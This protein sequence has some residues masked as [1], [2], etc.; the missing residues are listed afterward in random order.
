ME[1]APGFEPGITVLQTVALA[2]W[3]CR[4]PIAS[5][6]VYA[7]RARTSSPLATPRGSMRSRSSGAFAEYIVVRADRLALRRGYLR[8]GAFRRFAGTPL[9]LRVAGFVVSAASN[10]RRMPCS[11]T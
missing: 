10:K 8:D 11:N 4:H 3:L 7:F 9:R 6:A 2:T 1:A 5:T